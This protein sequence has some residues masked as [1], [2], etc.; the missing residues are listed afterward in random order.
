[1]ENSKKKSIESLETSLK[2]FKKLLTSFGGGQSSNSGSSKKESPSSKESSQGSSNSPASNSDLMNEGNSDKEVHD[3]NINV[4]T[5]LGQFTC[6]YGK[7][8]SNEEFEYLSPSDRVEASREGML[9]CIIKYI[10]QG[11]FSSPDIREKLKSGARVLDVGCGAGSWILDMSTAYP[12]S[13]FVGIDVSCIFPTKNSPPN[14][15]FLECNILNVNGIPFPDETFD[16]VYQRFMWSSLNENQWVSVIHD[17][18]RV[19]KKGGVLELMELD[20]TWEDKGTITNFLFNFSNDQY[21][22]KGI[23]P[24]IILEIPRMIEETGMLADINHDNR[25]VPLGGWGG[26]LGDMMLRHVIQGFETLKPAMTKMMRKSTEECDNMLKEFGKEC[27]ELKFYIR[28]Y[29][30]W[31]KKLESTS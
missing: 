8:D 13:T 18:A 31:C 30:F 20:N 12:N 11:N 16:F 17:L 21:R 14:V 3:P 2:S 10:W 29:R 9:N 23:N 6:N 15:G 24:H 28:Q 25:T 27:E 22:A 1:M 5:D 7:E 4:P 26:K 19:T